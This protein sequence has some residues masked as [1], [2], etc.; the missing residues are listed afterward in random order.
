MH[1]DFMVLESPFCNCL[2]YWYF[3]QSCEGG[4]VLCRVCSVMF[5]RFGSVICMQ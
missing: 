3:L 2:N 5:F 1:F 4:M